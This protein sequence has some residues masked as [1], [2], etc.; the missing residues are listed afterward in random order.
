[1][2]EVQLLFVVL[3]ALYGWECACWMRRGVVA[4]STWLGRDWR[5]LHPGTLAGN[6]RGGFVFAAP[7]PPLGTILTTN[8]FPLSLSPEAALAFVATNV[9]PGFRPAQSGRFV[10]FDEMREV[11]TRGR[12]VRV[13][14]GLLVAASSAALAP[15]FSLCML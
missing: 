14:G 5:L 6:Q 12:K 9:N 1:M 10:R 11:T 15:V 13:N 8:Q 4:F 3:A 2:S 7:L